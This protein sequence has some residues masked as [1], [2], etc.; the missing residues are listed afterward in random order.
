MHHF[1]MN[2]LQSLIYTFSVLPSCESTY[3]YVTELSGQAPQVVGDMEDMGGSITGMMMSFPGEKLVM[4]G[5]SSNS[6]ILYGKTIEQFL[7]LPAITSVS[8]TVMP[9]MLLYFVL[10]SPPPAA[11]WSASW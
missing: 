7:D 5:S 8:D 6:Q 11:A 9:A 1:G 3:Y 4:T 10:D 2:F